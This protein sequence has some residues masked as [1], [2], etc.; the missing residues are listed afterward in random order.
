MKNTITTYMVKDKELI[1]LGGTY[2]NKGGLAIIKG[3]F[4]VFNE[5]NISSRYIVD[6]EPL[7]PADFF[8]SRGLI[9]IYR[10]SKFLDKYSS[11]NLLIAFIN[12]LKN[13]FTSQIRQLRGIPI[14]YIGDSSLNDHRSVISL[15]GQI[16]SLLSLKL[17]TGS[18]LLINASMGYTRTKIG[19]MLLQSFLKNV[20]HL[21]ARGTAS[22]NNLLRLGVPPEKIT[23]VC[24]FAFYLNREET[25]R[26]RKYSKLINESKKPA[27]A[28]IF[29][30]PPRCVDR[31]LY[32]DAARKLAFKLRDKYEVFLVPTSYVPIPI[33]N[34]PMF[35]NELNKT[36]MGHVLNIEELEPEE[37]IDVFTNFEAVITARLH[38]AVFSAMAGVPTYHIYEADNSID[39]I[40]DIFGSLIP[41]LHV[42]DFVQRPVEQIT[43]TVNRLV[44]HRDEISQQ[45]ITRINVEKKRSIELIKSYFEKAGEM[46]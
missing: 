38:G 40:G 1:L 39:V 6:P 3:T 16:A 15:F 22:Y 4:K 41:L 34:D 5:L 46:K 11:L 23:T 26:S 20:D 12:L 33:E 24:D 45:L 44:R 27:M 19:K 9:P 42:P 28:L 17:A 32:I 18:R 29:K 31:S 2:S 36:N 14:W 8:S 35:L 10:F 13:S 7:F 37:I 25:A 21:F 43:E 30:N